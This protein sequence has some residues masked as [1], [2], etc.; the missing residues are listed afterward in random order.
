MNRRNKRKID[1]EKIFS[2]V[3]SLAIIAALV[4][5]VVSIVKSTTSAPKQNYI[6]LNVAED[7]T[8]TVAPTTIDRQAE[9]ETEKP[10]QK[11][12]KPTERATKPAQET[13]TV[14]EALTEP[15]TNE[16]PAAAN[17]EPTA[18]EVNAP[19]LSF[20][21]NSNLLWPVEGSILIGYNM[22]N[23]IY[24]PTLDLYKCSPSIVISAE[25]GTPVLSAAPGIVEDIYV[26]SVTG[27]TMVVSIGDGYKITYGQLGN[28][29]VGISDAVAAG[30]ELGRIAEPTK[31]FSV[32]GSNLYFE[33]T[34]EGTPVD[35]MLHLAERE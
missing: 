10:T 14:T 8:N 28:L 6:D 30:T 29:S 34:R 35:P 7:G 19:I 23:T 11:T 5:G 15:V 9:K 26:D 13:E 25:V 3:A 33:L 22:D 16:I 32:E 4:V 24:F 21:E 1:G 17:Q 2:I 31:Y 20:G 18:A 12:E 27:T